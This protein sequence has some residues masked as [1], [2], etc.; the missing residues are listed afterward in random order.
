[1]TVSQDA[2]SSSP[3]AGA[4]RSLA[5]L[6]ARTDEHALVGQMQQNK[7]SVFACDAFEVLEGGVAPRA[8]E[9]ENWKSVANTDIF[10]QIWD[11]I[12][13]NGKFWHYD[14]TVKVDPDAVFFPERLKMHLGKLKPPKDAAVYIKNCDFKFGFMG[15]LEIFSMKAM[16][17]FH[18]KGEQCKAKIG[19]EGGED[20]YMMT[21][22]DALGVNTMKDSTV[23]NDKYTSTAHLVLDDT[24][25]CNDGWTASF[26]PYRTTAVW[27]ACHSAAA[28]AVPA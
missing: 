11:Q 25:P 6:E 16:E 5:S 14:W 18:D 2:S 26:H 21:C 27:M 12:K 28:A 20:F 15:S 3:K 8:Q 24:S 19:H 4:V 17:R 10:I 9:N 1:M 22:M 23:L 7:M 13:A